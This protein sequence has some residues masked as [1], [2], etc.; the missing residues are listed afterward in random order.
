M[1]FEAI[2][3]WPVPAGMD[4]PE[5]E[6]NISSAHRLA[7]RRAAQRFSRQLVA[8]LGLLPAVGLCRAEK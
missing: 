1:P 5:A 7:P 6:Y 2:L 3:H 4:D 8:R